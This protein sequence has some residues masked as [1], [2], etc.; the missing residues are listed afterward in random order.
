MGYKVN[1]TGVLITV[2]PEEAKKRIL[3]AFR[4]ARANQA[5]AARALGCAENTFI[6]WIAKLKIRT[7]LTAIKREAIREGWIHDESRKGGRPPKKR[8][9]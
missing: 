6:R 2:Q 1:E 4:E 7:A 5:G 9:R 8:G 3:A